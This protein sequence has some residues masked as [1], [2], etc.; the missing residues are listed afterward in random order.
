[1]DWDKK[2][3]YILTLVDVKGCKQKKQDEDVSRRSR[4]LVYHL[5]RTNHERIPVC[6]S[7]FLLTFGIGEKTVYTWNDNA[8]TGI[9]KRLTK[10]QIKSRA[11][12]KVTFAND[13]LKHLPKMPLHYS[14][15][16]TSKQYLE[17]TFNSFC[18]L[19]NEYVE[20]S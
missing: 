9:P 14:R 16:S 6:K 15:S 12:E 5:K 7:M 2:T 18:K 1:M 20:S 13:F 3:V 17:P 8:N 10:R 4:Y 11:P 19:Y